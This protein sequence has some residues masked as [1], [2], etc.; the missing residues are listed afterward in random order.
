MQETERLIPGRV[1][2]KKIAKAVGISVFTAYLG[3]RSWTQP[4][5]ARRNLSLYA[6]EAIECVILAFEAG[7]WPDRKDLYPKIA[8]R[9]KKKQGRKNK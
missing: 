9:L 4:V 5:I 2:Q 8:P 3:L 6:P 7:K 1:A